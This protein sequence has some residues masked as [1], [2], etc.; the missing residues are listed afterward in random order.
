[1]VSSQE[2]DF[3]RV[4]WRLPQFNYE[5]RKTIIAVNVAEAL[6]PTFVSL[7]LLSFTVPS[8][9]ANLLVAYGKVFAVA[10]SLIPPSVATLA[11]LILFRIYTRSKPCVIAY[12]AGTLATLV[13]ADL[14]NI[15]KISK[16]GSPLGSIG[17]AGTSTEYT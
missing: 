4:K 17:G 1:M 8:Y 2:I 6:I 9:K 10:R 13:G 14:L 5:R 16:L 7:Y 11:A 3:F 15:R 12:I